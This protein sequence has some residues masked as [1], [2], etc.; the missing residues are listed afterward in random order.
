[1]LLFCHHPHLPTLMLLCFPRG[2]Y[3]CWVVKA[4]PCLWRE[5]SEALSIGMTNTIEQIQQMQ[6]LHSV[7]EEKE[8]CLYVR[9][10]LAASTK[11]AVREIMCAE[12][13]L[14]MLQTEA[15]KCVISI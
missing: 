8:G 14:C 2:M 9:V 3:I 13:C 15:L 7:G 4:V 10:C 6:Q 12:C 11:V 5:R 1:M